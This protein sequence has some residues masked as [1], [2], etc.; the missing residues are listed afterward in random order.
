MMYAVTTD[1]TYGRRVIWS[2]HRTSEAAEAAIP[3]FKAKVKEYFRV[4]KLRAKGERPGWE[5]G[6]S[7]M[8]KYWEDLK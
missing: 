3:A 5:P 1:F 2:L 4:S 6:D 8:A 7:P